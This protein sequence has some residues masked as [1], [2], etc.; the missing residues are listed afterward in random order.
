V[1]RLSTDSGQVQAQ[2][3][4]APTPGTAERRPTSKVAQPAVPLEAPERL[5]P[6]LPIPIVSIRRKTRGSLIALVLLVILL[7]GATWWVY[8]TASSV[9][10]TKPEPSATKAP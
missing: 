7:A 3:T 8:S 2:R 5:S 9:V 4:T 10:Q 1:Y 6:T